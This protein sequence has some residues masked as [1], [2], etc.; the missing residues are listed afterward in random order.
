MTNKEESEFKM[1]VLKRDVNTPPEQLE[2]DFKELEPYNQIGPD[3]LECLNHS[4][5]KFNG[6]AE[7]I[8]RTKENKDRC[9]FRRGCIFNREGICIADM[10]LGSIKNCTAFTDCTR[11]EEYDKT[12]Q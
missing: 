1:A 9:I 10:E 2:K 8:E 6:I 5:E 4:L 12:H 3:V 11:L 7:E